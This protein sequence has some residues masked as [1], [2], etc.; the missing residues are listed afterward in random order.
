MPDL[1]QAILDNLRFLLDEYTAALAYILPRTLAMILTLVLGWVLG[2]L[3]GKLAATIVKLGKADEALMATPLGAHLS[4]AGYTLSTFVDL[5]TRVTVY[6]FSVALAIRVLR[7]PEAEIVAQS[8]FVVV[9]RIVA[10]VLV[11]IVGLLIVEKIFEFVGRI[12]KETSVGVSATINVV[13]GIAILLIVTAALSS[14]GVDLTPV[15]HV[16]VA[17]AQG[18]GIGLGI[19]AVLIAIA[20]YRDEL[21]KLLASIRGRESVQAGKG[22]SIE[23]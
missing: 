2:R 18:A 20:L 16:I 1:I 8:L 9:G 4:K 19:A 14:A 15:T 13:H 12:F 7:V 22:K 3:L 10:G 5:A 21:L 17:F 23:D 11:L 6:V